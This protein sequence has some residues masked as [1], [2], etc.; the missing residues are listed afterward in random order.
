MDLNDIYET[1]KQQKTI[2][3]KVHTEYFPGQAT[4]LATEKASIKLG[5]LKSYET[6]F[7]NKMLWEQISIIGKI[8]K[9]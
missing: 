9:H 8:D 3:S 6:S 4:S 5:N 1:G 7:P 2:S